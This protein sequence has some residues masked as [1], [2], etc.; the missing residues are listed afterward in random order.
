MFAELADV[1]GGGLSRSKLLELL[2]KQGDMLPQKEL[3]ELLQVR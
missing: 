3:A 2:A 1:T